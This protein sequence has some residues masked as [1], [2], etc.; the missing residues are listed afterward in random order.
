MRMATLV[1]SRLMPLWI[2]VFATWGIFSPDLFAGWHLAASPALGFVL[3]IM[4]ITLDRSRL[5][6]L[7][8]NPRIPLL[9][10][11]GKWVI[12]PA[13]SVMIGLLFFGVSELF[14]GVVMAGI[15]PSGTSANLNSLI[16][17]GDLALSVTMSAID[18][19]IG[20]LLTPLLAKWLI[21]TSVQFAYLPFLWKMIKIVFLPLLLGIVVQHFFPRSHEA[22][23]PYASILSALSLYIVV[24]GI[25]SNASSSLL[26][27][28]AIL[29]ALFFCVILQILL[30]MLGGYVYAR[31]LRCSDAECR[32]MIFEVGICNTALATVLANDTFGP[33]AGLAS[34]ANMVCNLTLGSLLAVILASTP[35]RT[36]SSAPSTIAK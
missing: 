17:R 12:G 23:K 32:S 10:S 11:L 18:T 1:I 16:G 20:P 14:Y 29:P 33:L 22:I 28:A 30:Q 26:E 5:G 4:G 34:M 27:H 13:V 36:Y 21:G 3:F 2:I 35:L 24:I 19:M 7:L 25:A 8:Q 9:G 15:V 31:W 6:I